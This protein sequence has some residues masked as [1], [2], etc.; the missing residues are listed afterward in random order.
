M[1]AKDETLD[2]RALAVTMAI[3]TQ[4]HVSRVRYRHSRKLYVTASKHLKIQNGIVKQ[5]RSSFAEGQASE[6]TLIREEMNT[7]AS[8][9]AAD[10]AYS[11]LQNAYANIFASIGIDPYVDDL[12]SD[13]GVDGLAEMLRDVWIER[14]DRSGSLR[15]KRAA[16][17]H[18]VTN[19]VSKP[20]KP[21]AIDP[22]VKETHG[23]AALEVSKKYDS[24]IVRIESRGK[25][26]LFSKLFSGGDR[27][28]LAKK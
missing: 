20:V 7:L 28:S 11:D 26:S 14:G 3:M 21:D 27:R 12:R 15:A 6:Q 25:R 24:E 10:I 23:W 18:I 17:A 5:I 1:K 22:I 4:V 8:Q 13:I 9:V 2:A 19:S 16:E